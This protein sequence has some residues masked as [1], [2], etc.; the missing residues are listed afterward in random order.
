MT[1]LARYDTTGDDEAYRIGGGWPKVRSRARLRAEEADLDPQPVWKTPPDD[2][3]A[4]VL[5]MARIWQ[6]QMDAEIVEAA[7]RFEAE[8]SAYIGAAAKLET[9]AFVPMFRERDPWERAIMSLIELCEKPADEDGLPP[10][11][12]AVSAIDRLMAT[13]SSQTRLPSFETHDDGAVSLRWRQ[14]GASRSFALHFGDQRISAIYSAPLLGPGFGTS[15]EFG[16]TTSLER[17]LDRPEI[18]DLIEK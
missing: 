11:R 12:K 5:K 16:D 17:V 4:D 1:A 10:S 15:I 6:A 3:S 7:K 9:R 13:I 18:R 2:V 14:K 8:L